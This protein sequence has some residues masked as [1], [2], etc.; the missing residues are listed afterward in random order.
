M[1]SDRQGLRCWKGHGL[2]VQEM[3][4]GG[5]ET[6]VGLTVDELK[7]A[8]GDMSEVTLS[9]TRVSFGSIAVPDELRLF[10]RNYMDGCSAVT[11]DMCRTLQLKTFKAWEQGI[12]EAQ[13]TKEARI[14]LDAIRNLASS[15]ESVS[16]EAMPN[17]LLGEAGEPPLALVPMKL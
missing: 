2:L 10:I 15:Y 12:L 11:R 8:A 4:S 9:T 5:V 3:V 1:R 7:R 6:I 17:P 13:Q 16:S 14:R